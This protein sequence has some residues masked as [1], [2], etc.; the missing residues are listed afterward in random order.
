MLIGFFFL[1][2]CKSAQTV[3]V[4]VTLEESKLSVS[5]E[6]TIP[7]VPSDWTYFDCPQRD[8]CGAFRFAFPAESNGPLEIQNGNVFGSYFLN[9]A[10]FIISGGANSAYTLEQSV[11]CLDSSYPKPC[12]RKKEFIIDLPFYSLL[13]FTAHTPEENANEADVVLYLIKTKDSE[14]FV[15]AHVKTTEEEKF[16]DTTMLNLKMSDEYGSA[17]SP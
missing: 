9:N 11:E 16:V 15:R 5:Q 8:Y 3:Q 13:K 14:F 7:A 1:C 10:Y 2:S 12:P 6:A 4:P 17:G